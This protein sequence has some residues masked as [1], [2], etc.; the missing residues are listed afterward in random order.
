MNL[1]YLLDGVTVDTSGFCSTFAP[2]IKIFGIV[3]WFIK[4]G[5]PITLLV[6][7]MY[8][9]AKAITSKDEEGIR[10]AWISL[11]KKAIAAVSVFLV[12][13]IIGTVMEIAGGKP[14]ELCTKCFNHPFDSS[15][16]IGSNGTDPTTGTAARCGEVHGTCDE[17]YTCK[18]I[19]GERHYKCV[20]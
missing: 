20:K 7:G 3:Y 13:T 8:Q 17:G 15:C 11:G 4:I 6:I 19:S 18:P 12:A 2:T 5:T 10:K 1:I 9:A 16:N 14:N